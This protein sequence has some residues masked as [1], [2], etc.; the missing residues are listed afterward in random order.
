MTVSLRFLKHE[1]CHLKHLNCFLSLR[2]NF[3]F[4]IV[5]DCLSFHG[6]H[7]KG[8]LDTTALNKV[9]P[10]TLEKMETLTHFNA[11]DLGREKVLQNCIADNSIALEEETMF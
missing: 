1:N 9:R 2:L 5:A 6:N 4:I 8:L 3:A 10:K 7:L 11:G